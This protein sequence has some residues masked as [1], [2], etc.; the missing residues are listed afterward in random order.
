MK[1]TSR[2]QAI[3]EI[4]RAIK[5][6]P[7]APKKPLESVA[8]FLSSIRSIVTS[9]VIVIL[10]FVLVW[11]GIR[12]FTAEY[13]L[14]EPFD[15]P[16]A[17]EK[18]GFNGRVIANK[19][20]NQINVIREKAGASGGKA[21]IRTR[22]GGENRTLTRIAAKT[23]FMPTWSDK[24]V[25]MQVPGTGVSINSAILYFKGA[26]TQY[27]PIRVAGEIVKCNNDIEMTIRVKDMPGIPI[28]E[29]K[30]LDDKLEQAA[31]AVCGLTQPY[32]LASYLYKIGESQ[33]C[34]RIIKDALTRGS[35][36]DA[37]WA[38]TLLGVLSA[39]RGDRY[40]A[41]ANYRK[42]IEIDP[43]FVDA[44]VAW[45]NVLLDERMFDEAIA[46]YKIATE[47]DPKFTDAYNNWGIAFKEQEDFELAIALYELA[48]ATDP[49]AAYVY[50]N[51][52]AT[53]LKQGDLGRA[54][55]NFQKAIEVDPK[56]AVS[57]NAWGKALAEQMKLVEA[58]AKY[59]NATEIDPK[60]ADAY[61]NWGNA[62][63]DQKKFDQACA[64][65]KKA[66]EADP[67][68]VDAY[69]NWGITL[70]EQGNIPEAIAKYEKAVKLD[71]TFVDAY[72]A[73]GDA[74][75]DQRKY[76]DSI[77]KYKIVIEIDPRYVY[78][79]YSWGQA[80][81]HLK[82]IPGAIAKYRKAAEIDVSGEAGRYARVRLAELNAK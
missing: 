82:D 23:R 45:G 61:N 10:V 34:R 20:Y 35:R 58:I 3:S 43:K 44:H 4:L 62:L 64:K 38:Y 67:K 50:T 70:Q 78:A 79:Y 8:G 26:F 54:Y 49:N 75:F 7:P 25:D 51:M 36:S 40:G 14:I 22:R 15:V 66:V 18:E 9:L 39:D 21:A 28:R 80:L 46:R 68:F 69:Y 31:K 33:A 74:L 53:L 32:L 13:V 72:D 17:L 48:I 65:Y 27:E 5:P 73:W 30:K 12:E 6:P 63:G 2:Q 42:A 24:K 16:Q 19:L 52:G 29:G 81:E 1:R 55:V 41:I 77:A 37:P 59:K 60:Y 11:I 47:I 76:K 71:P 56:P 57:Y